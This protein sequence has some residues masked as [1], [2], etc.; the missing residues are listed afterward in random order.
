MAYKYKIL[1]TTDVSA[2]YSGQLRPDIRQRRETGGKVRK[3]K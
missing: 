1:K 2:A 3:K